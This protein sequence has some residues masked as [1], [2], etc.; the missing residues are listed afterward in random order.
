MKEVGNIRVYNVSLHVPMPPIRAAPPNFWEAIQGWDNTWP[1][2]NLVISGDISWIVKSVVDDSCVAV[3]DGSYKKVVYPNFN[4]A[5]FVFECSKGQGRLMG[6]FI[7]ST[8]NA[9][10]Y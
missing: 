5:A 3:T 2:D 1:W 9:G 4:L 8:P 7:K 6:T 10:S